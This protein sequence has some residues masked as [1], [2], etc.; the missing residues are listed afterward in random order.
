MNILVIGGAGFI[1]S[2]MVKQLG[3]S[4][5]HV[6]TLD[7]LSNGHR[8]AVLYGDFV[9][10]D[11]ADKA[12]LVQVLQNGRF[13]AVMH[14]ASFIQVGESVQHPAQ[15]YENNVANTLH[16]LE[17]MRLADVKRFVFSSTAASFGQ[18]EWLLRSRG[19]RSCPPR[20]RSHCFSVGCAAT[21][22]RPRSLGGRCFSSQK[23]ARLATPVCGFGRDRGPR[24]GL[25]K[26]QGG[27]AITRGP[28]LN[29]RI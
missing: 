25:G 7:N 24:M 9:Q 29:I 10:G 23:S 8:D 1:G 26:L 3:R 2:H 21:R 12:L 22:W 4:A 19:H 28:P 15:Y 18:R 11:L 27:Q 16:L 5:C 20:H 6:T 13:D 14:F 17:A